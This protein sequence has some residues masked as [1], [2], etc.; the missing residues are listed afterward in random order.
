MANEFALHGLDGALAK[1]REV[2]REV[3][4]KGTRSAGTKAMRIVRDAARARARG[5]DDPETASNIAKAITTR[6]DR[7]ASQREGGVVVKVGV[8]GGAKPVKG[9]EDTGHW[10]LVEFGTSEMPAHPFMR[11]ALSENTEKVV[12]AFIA[13][14]E[15]AIDKA[16]AKAR[17]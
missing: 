6:Y 10:R 17:R 7:K 11:P 13:A 16:L 15:P 2:S 12:D 5:L 8:A 9:N 14:I 4:T 1:I 3:A